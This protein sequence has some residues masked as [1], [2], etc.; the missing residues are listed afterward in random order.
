MQFSIINKYKATLSGCI[1]IICC[2]QEDG[3]IKC[4]PF[5]VRFGKLKV[6]HSKEKEISIKI[7]GQLQEV[8]MK[9]EKSGEG[10][11]EEKKI[12]ELKR[13]VY[14]RELND[15]PSPNMNFASPNCSDDNISDL[16]RNLLHIFLI[17]SS[18]LS[19]IWLRIR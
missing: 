6:L 17:N 9:L 12:M 10:Y 1:D 7:N 15:Y 19:T 13:Q 16:E 2:I 11:F 8:K 18:F 3:S 4:T 5:H 14:K